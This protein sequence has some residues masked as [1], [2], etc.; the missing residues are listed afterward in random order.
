[1]GNAHTTTACSPQRLSM[2]SDSGDLDATV[3]PGRYRV[4]AQT[5]S[6]SRKVS[7]ISSSA[8][9]PFAIQGITGTGD[10]T[11]RGVP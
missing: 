3:P 1:S 9:A 5:S 10:V 8:Q 7:G 11:V 6:G 2:R 4:D